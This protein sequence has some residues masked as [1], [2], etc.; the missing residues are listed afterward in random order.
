MTTFCVQCTYTVI[1][2]YKF[3]Q[4]KYYVIGS[5]KTANFGIGIKKKVNSIDLYTFSKLQKH[6]TLVW[7]VTLV[8]LKDSKV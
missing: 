7:K 1:Q 2:Q 6:V 8:S 4:D 3:I 5:E